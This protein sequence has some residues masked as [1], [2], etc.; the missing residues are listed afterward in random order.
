MHRRV[1]ARHHI[2]IQNCVLFS[3]RWSG[4]AVGSEMFGGLRHLRRGCRINSFDFP[5]RYNPRN[6]V[7]L[8]TNKKRGGAM[9]GV[10]VRRF[11]GRRIDHDRAHP[12]TLYSNQTGDHPALI[13][14]VR[15]EHM[16]H[17]GA[18]S[19]INLEG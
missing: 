12:T 5:G 10:Y 6:P 1:P 11:Q 8:K 13:R 14:N 9:D 2:V 17:D 16:V 15:V 3:G 19:A 7:F 4:L 18:R